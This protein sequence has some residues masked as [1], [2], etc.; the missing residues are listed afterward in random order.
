ML[1]L[2]GESP[3]VI[4]PSDDFAACKFYNIG[5]PF[6]RPFYGKQSCLT[7][8]CCK[9]AARPHR[10]MHEIAVSPRH[11]KTFLGKRELSSRY[12]AW[13]I[14]T[15]SSGCR[16]KSDSHQIK[17]STFPG[18]PSCFPVVCG[19]LLSVPQKARGFGPAD[20]T[21]TDLPRAQSPGFRKSVRYRPTGTFFSS[22]FPSF[23][24][25][26]SAPSAD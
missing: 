19:A 7:G 10:L 8:R 24:Q 23:W 2:R 16:G 17:I 26:S 20:H 9:S 18:F 15:G 14:N 6:C 4:R 3:A 22:F 25:K 12:G 5:F 21:V 13:F 11:H 1:R